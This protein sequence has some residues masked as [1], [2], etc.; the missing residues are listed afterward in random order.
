MKEFIVM[1]IE[2]IK[3]LLS[4][5]YLPDKDIVELNAQLEVL[6]EVLSHE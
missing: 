5:E 3:Q 1:K 6:E 2:E 4:E